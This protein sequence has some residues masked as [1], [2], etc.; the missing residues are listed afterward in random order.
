MF[1]NASIAG[2]VGTPTG[3]VAWGTAGDPTCSGEGE[4]MTCGAIPVMLWT[5]PNGTDWSRVS[6]LAAFKD[7]RIGNIAYGSLGLLAVGNTGFTEP[8]IWT[9]TTGA[10]WQRLTLPTDV[11]TDAHLSTISATA[12]GY[13]VGGSTGGTAPTSGGV[14]LE[15]TSVAAAWWSD[16]QTWN[17]ATVNRTGGIGTSLDAIYVGANG[18]VGIGSASGGKVGTAWNSSDGK[19]WQPIDGAPSAATLPSFTVGDD[20][21]R[22]VAVGN[23]DKGQLVI[24]ISDDGATWRAI[25]FSGATAT[26]PNGARAFVVPGG[27][28]VVASPGSSATTQTPVWMVT[29]Q[30]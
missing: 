15:A 19:T 12:S 5:S 4:G 24:W 26:V 10:S 21:T 13:V 29:A 9:S 18:M 25:P 22:L 1:F 16:G 20:G 27:L 17:K 23:A 7:A 11:F 2:L 28:I 14:A 8:A 30:P 6:G 3:L